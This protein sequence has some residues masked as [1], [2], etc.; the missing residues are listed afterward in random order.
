MICFSIIFC[1]KWDIIIWSP[2]N[3]TLIPTRYYLFHIYVCKCFLIALIVNNYNYPSR[4]YTR[5]PYCLPVWRTKCQKHNNIISAVALCA[6]FLTLFRRN[7]K[8]RN[9]ACP[10]PPYARAHPTKYTNTYLLCHT[11]RFLAFRNHGKRFSTIK[12][13]KNIFIIH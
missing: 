1:F 8:G 6:Y 13:N 2:Y 4:L 7:V 11:I 9:V 5:P 3:T 12:K 10:M